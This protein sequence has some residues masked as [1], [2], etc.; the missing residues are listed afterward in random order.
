MDVVLVFSI[1]SS[2]IDDWLKSIY[3]RELTQEVIEEFK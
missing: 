1:Y 2:E 3:C